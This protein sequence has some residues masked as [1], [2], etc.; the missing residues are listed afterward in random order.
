MAENLINPVRLMGSRR[1]T[2]SKATSRYQ[3]I[4][5]LSSILLVYA[6]T[7]CATYHVYQRGGKGGYDLGS[8]PGTQWSKRERLDAL[9][10]GL[11]REDYVV[12]Q[13]KLPDGTRV[14]F[15]EVQIETNPGY[16]LA[17]VLTLGIWIPIDVS[18]RCA[19]PPG[20]SG[21]L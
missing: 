9:F 14:G 5:A 12:D 17:T 20:L 18:Y 21:S 11:V 8:Q 4:C 15:D 16:V 1:Q 3:A 13:C 2:K 10:W 19:K 7:G 6:S